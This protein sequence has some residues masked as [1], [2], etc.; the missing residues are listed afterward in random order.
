MNRRP[1][2][3][4]WVAA[5][6]L[7][8]VGVWS[9]HYA[10]SA[11]L[12]HPVQ[13]KVVALRPTSLPVSTTG[14]T[15]RLDGLTV[16]TRVDTKT[17]KSVESPDLRA[18]LTLRNTTADEAIRLLSGNVEY[19]DADGAVMPL[20]KDQ[21]SSGFSF[22]PDQPDGLVPGQETSQVIRVPFPVAAIKTNRLHD[23]R[24]HLTYRATPYRNETVDGLVTFPG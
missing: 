16:V 10:H 18:T 8:V 17:G 19:V 15:G 21:G 20:A 5:L 12:A 24:L 2:G 4:W 9:Q 14:L 7:L 22:Y 3:M 6:A 1:S 11:A 13:R 23:I